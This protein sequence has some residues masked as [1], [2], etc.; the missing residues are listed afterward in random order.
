[1]NPVRWSMTGK[2][3]KGSY[4]DDPPEPIT[5]VSGFCE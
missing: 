3:A 2:R 5:C 1:M 4:M